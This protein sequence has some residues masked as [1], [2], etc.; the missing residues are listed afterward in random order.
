MEWKLVCGNC[1]SD[2]FTSAR[3]LAEDPSEAICYECGTRGY[4]YRKGP[5]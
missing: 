4:L 2:H 5:L 3:S 1:Q